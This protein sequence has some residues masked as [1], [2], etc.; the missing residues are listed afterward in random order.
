[1]FED[2]ILVEKNKKIR[3]ENEKKR[4]FIDR[5]RYKKQEEEHKKEDVEDEEMNAMIKELKAISENGN[6]DEYEHFN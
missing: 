4:G 2:D 5:M 6:F 1:M 3:R